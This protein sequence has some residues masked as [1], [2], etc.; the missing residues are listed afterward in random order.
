MS[1]L[2]RPQLRLDDKTGVV[3][4]GGAVIDTG[5]AGAAPG[6]AILGAPQNLT[7][8]STALVVSDLVASALANL[9]WSRPLT[10]GPVANYLVQWSLA[11]T[12]TNPTGIVA[13]QTSAAVGGLPAGRLVYFRVAAIAAGGVQGAWSASASTTTPSDTA[14]PAAPTSLVTNWSGLTGDL[15]LTWDNPTSA[16]LRDV[17][18]RIYASN[19][20]ALLRETY[21]SAGRFLWPRGLNYA[22][23]SNVPDASVYI[24]LTARS[25][26]GVLSATDLTGTATLAVPSTPTGL[27]A[28]WGPNGDLIVT[29]TVVVTVAVYRLSIDGVARDT[30]G[31]RYVY[32]LDLNRQEHSGTADPSLSLS[33]VAVDALGQSSTAATLTATNAAPPATTLTV[34]AGFSLVMVSIVASSAQD[35]K[36]Y[37]LRVYRNSSLVRTVFNASASFSYAVEDGN[38]TYQFDV[39]VRDR[40]NQVGTASSLTSGAELTD[41]AEFVANLRS[42]L[43]YSDSVSTAADTLGGLKD[44][45]RAT[46]VVTYAASASAWRWTQADWQEDISHQTSDFSSSV[47][48]SCYIGTSRDGTTWT[49]YAGGTAASGRWQPVAQ[50]SEAA[51]QTAAT[52]LAAG[53]WRIDLPAPVRCRYIKL[54]HRNTTLSYALREWFPSTLIRGTYV[55]AE[56]ITTVH[57]AAGS[58]TADKISAGALDAFV[59]T[60][61]TIRTAASGSRVEMSGNSLKAYSGSSVRAKFDEGGLTIYDVGGLDSNAVFFRRIDNDHLFARMS[62]DSATV[63]E[64]E[65]TAITVNGAAVV[66][67]K[68]SMKAVLDP[69]NTNAGTSSIV[70]TRTATLDTIALNTDTVSLNLSSLNEAVSI[71]GAGGLTVDTSIAA[72]GGINVGY[73]AGA[74]TGSVRA[75][76]D[77][78]G[79]YVT[80]IGGVIPTS[81]SGVDLR[82]DGVN[83]R[84]QLRSHLSGTGY[85]PLAIN[86][87]QLSFFDV[88]TPVSKQSVTALSMSVGT[89]SDTVADVGASFNQTTL[90][91]NFRDLV[92]KVNSI[93][94]VLVAYGLLA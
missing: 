17:R 21:T 76:G 13:Y 4:G 14:P 41:M 80:A 58:I 71:F 15:L 47:S 92:D 94:S 33:L 31:G 65:L 81:K 73:A 51:A 70:L 1:R 86:A 75:T 42:G 8:A 28:S 61:A 26:G 72:G 11:S 12:F 56:S 38:G 19:G 30:I 84:A 74:A 9:T 93:R 27:A 18:V 67:S 45:D 36:D 68:S 40:F 43:L 87:S 23:T 50:A 2:K 53:V 25:V 90:N 91:N 52:V 59:I 48:T 16:N 39:A 46:N 57:L 77:G 54:G 89:G 44:G 7:V 24:V 49:W 63:N 35:L 78:D 10:A 60:G 83:D 88:T 55:E 69:G 37:R 20:G 66:G 6:V 29:W 32:P 79:D 3:F 64:I 85:R 62:G 5:G 22:D 82:Y 34:F